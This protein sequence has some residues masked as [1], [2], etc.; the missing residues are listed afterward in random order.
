MTAIPIACFDIDVLESDLL[1]REAIAGEKFLGIAMKEYITLKGG[2]AVIEE[3]ARLVAIYPYREADYSKVSHNT[4]N[5][6]ML[7]C[8]AP[9]ITLQK[10]NNSALE[11]I[12]VLTNL[13]LVRR[14]VKCIK[15]GNAPPLDKVEIKAF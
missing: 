7:M 3:G 4:K 9:G 13:S 12:K 15:R 1:M 6:L 5:V 11:A 8:G 14:I 10:L 2:E